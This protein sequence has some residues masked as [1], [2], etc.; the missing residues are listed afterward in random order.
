MVV[1]LQQVCSE[2]LY[3]SARRSYRPTPSS[4]LRANPTD[5]ILIVTRVSHASSINS[6]GGLFCPSWEGVKLR[7]L[8]PSRND[9]ALLSVRQWLPSVPFNSDGLAEDLVHDLALRGKRIP[10][11]IVM[12]LLWRTRTVICML[13]ML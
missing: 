3:S 10:C 11:K 12:R 4:R 6:T 8:P 9:H 13:F 5:L 1:A 2:S 7:T